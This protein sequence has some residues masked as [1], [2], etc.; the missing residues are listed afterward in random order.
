MIPFKETNE[1]NIIRCTKPDKQTKFIQ[2]NNKK[3][4]NTYKADGGYKKCNGF[5]FYVKWN[6]RKQTSYVHCLKCKELLF[7]Y[8]LNMSP[9]M[10]DVKND[11]EP[12]NNNP[13]T[14]NI[15]DTPVSFDFA[16]D[17]NNTMGNLHDKSIN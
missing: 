3:V 17:S 5:T 13:D 9:R 15:N 11:N 12:R 16:P 10:E 2:R 14:S 6:Q 1:E 4:Q 8:H 7:E